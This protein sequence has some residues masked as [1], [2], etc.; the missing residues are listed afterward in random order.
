MIDVVSLQERQIVRVFDVP[1]PV[2]NR[3]T[4]LVY[5]PKQRF[6]ARLPEQVA[7]AVAERYG[8]TAREIDSFLGASNLAR[9][10]FTVERPDGGHRPRSPV[11]AGRRADDSWIDRVRERADPRLGEARGSLLFTRA[12]V[13]AP[14][15]Y[16]RASTR[17]PLSPT[18][19]LLELIDVRGD[20]PTALVRHVDA[21]E[22]EWRIRVYRRGEP[23]ALADLLPMLG[24]VGLGRRSTSTRSGS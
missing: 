11:R 13:A 20:H 17:A 7:A 14:G 19:S 5:L 23:I 8:S 2:G 18:S 24:H 22:G 12:G 9:I 4:V 1:E 3:S 21:A 6:H 10:T 15:S 16:R